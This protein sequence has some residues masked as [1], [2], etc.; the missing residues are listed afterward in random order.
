MALS[1]ERGHFP[2]A[3]LSVICMCPLVFH[4]LE[5][6]CRCD[7]DGHWECSI[8]R[9]QDCTALAQRGAFRLS[10]DAQVRVP[11]H[12][13]SQGQQALPDIEASVRAD[14]AGG[15]WPGAVL[16]PTSGSQFCHL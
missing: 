9:E 10:Q 2:R 3:P 15:T 13:D 12:G 7:W 4:W 14:L 8:H 1:W 11:V 5:L 6:G 16:P